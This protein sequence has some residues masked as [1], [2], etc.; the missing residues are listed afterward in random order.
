MQQLK[1]NLEIDGDQFE[2]S[3]VSVDM[4]ITKHISKLRKKVFVFES[5]AA[6]EKK[7]KQRIVNY[8][9][10]MGAETLTQVLWNEAFIINNNGKH[11]KYLYFNNRFQKLYLDKQFY[12]WAK[13]TCQIINESLMKLNDLDNIN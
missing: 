3:N 6:D 2:L 7:F 4:V 10:V 5:S 13:L 12:L 9:L 11:T 8:I 1:L